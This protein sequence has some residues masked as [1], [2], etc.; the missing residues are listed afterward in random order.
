MI[1][2]NKLM[3]MKT[4]NIKI[5]ANYI[6]ILIL[7]AKNMLKLNKYNMLQNSTDF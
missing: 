1:K 5:K 6:L 2:S 7:H 3:K 4:E